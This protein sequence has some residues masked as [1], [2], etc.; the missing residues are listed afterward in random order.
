MEECIIV[1]L[2]L[3]IGI[4]AGYYASKIEKAL[5]F[6]KGKITK[7]ETVEPFVTN[8]DPRFAREDQIGSPDSSVILPKSP[9]LIEWE[10]TQEIEKLNRTGQPR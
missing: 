9:Q 4:M 3:I 2:S 8:S 5:H 6:I 10:E 7:E 1:L